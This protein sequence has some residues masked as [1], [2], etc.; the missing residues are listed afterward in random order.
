[1]APRPRELAQL[2]PARR[3]R[4]DQVLVLELGEGGIDRARPR[5]PPA[6]AQVLDRLHQLVAVARL[7]AEQQQQGQADVAPPPAAA[8][9][10]EH[11][12]A[13][14]RRAEIGVLAHDT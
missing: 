4:T 14:E 9:A 10:A 7:P 3:G 8:A 11:G 6:T 13:A 12:A 1:P 2:G 5:P